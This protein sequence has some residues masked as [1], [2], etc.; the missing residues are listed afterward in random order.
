MRYTIWYQTLKNGVPK[1]GENAVLTSW[2]ALEWL[3]QKSFS[4]SPFVWYSNSYLMFNLSHG[5]YM[6]LECHTNGRSKKNSNCFIAKKIATLITTLKADDK[7]KIGRRIFTFKIWSMCN[8]SCELDSFYF[9]F[10]NFIS[11]DIV[12][13]Q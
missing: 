2:N 8:I 3:S 1:V 7:I 13:C 10:V 4:L 9:V 11:F 6:A 5:M 12:S